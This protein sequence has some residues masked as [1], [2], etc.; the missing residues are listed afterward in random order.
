M[1]I[2][3]IDKN[4]VV[5]AAKGEDF[6]FVN[7]LEYPFRIYGVSMYDGHPGFYRMPPEIASECNDGVNYLN[8]HTA[9][10]RVRFSTDSSVIAIK[11]E[12]RE[13]SKMPHMPFTGSCGFD[14]YRDTDGESAYVGTFVPPVEIT[15]GYSSQLGTGSK[16]MCSYTINFPL[17]SGV[18]S[19][20]VGFESGSTIAPGTDYEPILPIVYYGSSIT[21]G[22]CAS[23]PG[24]SY[25]A[26]ITRKY[27]IDHINLGFSG[28][29]KGEKAMSDYL[30]SIDM[31]VFVCDYDH[32]APD[33]KHLRKTLAPLVENIR[34]ANPDLP[35]IMMSRPQC[36]PSQDELER[37]EVVKSVFEQYKSNGDNN[38]FF[39]DGTQIPLIF[40]ADSTTVDNCHPNDL[41]FM[42]MARAVENILD[43]IF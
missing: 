8:M 25:Q 43:S 9:G 24:N 23:R 10:G 7:I 20:Y 3:D 37:R 21:Q 22:G 1:K 11:A 2:S 16:K 31:S 4:L 5:K 28:S 15:D 26:I 32:N 36:R 13:L 33:V 40:G 29:A 17:Y 6:A 39:I 42:C 30:S 14:L 38:I 35:I 34:S 18:T 41:G 19:L 12:M 27:N